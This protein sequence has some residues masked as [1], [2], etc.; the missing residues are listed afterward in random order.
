MNKATAYVVRALGFGE[1]EDEWENLF[2]VMCKRRAE[3]FVRSL[4]YRW[5][6]QDGDGL[7]LAE[8]RKSPYWRPSFDYEEVDSR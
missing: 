5:D 8:I 7:T 1:D 2:V 3:R 6:M 4:Q